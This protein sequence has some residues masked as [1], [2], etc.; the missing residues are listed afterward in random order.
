M[1]TARYARQMIVAEIGDAGQARL[2]AAAA[3]LAG[4]GLAHEIATAYAMRAG[5][6]TIEPGPIDEASLAPPFLELRSTRAVVAGSRAA[7]SV[8]RKALGVR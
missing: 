5:I 4:V 3:P 6:G 1:N 2:K 8:M 7:L